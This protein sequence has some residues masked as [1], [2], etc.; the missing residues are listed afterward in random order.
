MADEI[1]FNAKKLFK[2][3]ADIEPKLKKEL[4][5]K[6]KEAAQPALTAVI[7]GIPSVNPYVSNI[8]TP[9]VNGRLAW[10][11]I[12]PANKVI[13]ST[14]NKVSKVSAV[15]SLFR[16]WVQSPA[17][18]IADTAGKG[19]GVPTRTTTNPYQVNGRMRTHRV[20]TQGR[21]MIRH[22]QKQGRRGSNFVYPSVEQ[23]LPSVT[24]KLKLIVDSFAEKIT[25]EIN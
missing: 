22:L 12:K 8:R 23:S 18:V 5:K 20:T 11:A 16:L 2:Q 14:S 1:V 17:T 15:T 7:Q 21:S 19:S 13:F 4:I 24:S 10:G 9:N 3:L 25:K 6:S